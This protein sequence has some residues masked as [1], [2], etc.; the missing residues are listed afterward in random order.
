MNSIVR[1]NCKIDVTISGINHN[2]PRFI[3]S[4]SSTKCIFSRVCSSTNTNDSVNITCKGNRVEAARLGSI[5]HALSNDSF[6]MQIAEALSEWSDYEY[7]STVLS[8]WSQMQQINEDDAGD[9][10]CVHPLSTFSHH[11]NNGE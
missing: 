4:R 8:A 7:L 5:L 2:S 3:Y 9:E 11:M 10:Y 6:R 1:I